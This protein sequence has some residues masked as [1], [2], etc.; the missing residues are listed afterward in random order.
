M[1]SDNKNIAAFGQMLDAWQQGDL[2][3]VEELVAPDYVGHMSGGDRNIDGLKIRISE[4]N[5][6]FPDIVFRIDDQFANGEKVVTRLTAR[7]TDSAS[8]VA[9]VLMGINISRFCNGLMCEEWATWEAVTSS[10]S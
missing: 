5:A 2:S 4:F 8:R 7:G 3:K 6:K 9:V 1:I 10:Q